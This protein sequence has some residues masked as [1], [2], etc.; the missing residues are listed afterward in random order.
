MLKNIFSLFKRNKFFVKISLSKELYA[1]KTLCTFSDL[2][3]A[4]GVV[5]YITE[6]SKNQEGK[7]HVDNIRV[8]KK[9]YEK[10]KE[11]LHTNILSK[12]NKWAKMY[13]SK[14]LETEHSFDCLLFAP[15]IDESVPNDVIYIYL[16]GHKEYK[17]IKD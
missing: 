9:T 2:Y 13:R 7:Y 5:V 16:P 10:I 8:N 14:K 4:S 1:N 15:K 11:I 12:K 3:E 17:T 6:M